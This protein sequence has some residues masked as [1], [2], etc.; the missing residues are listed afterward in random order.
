MSTCNKGANGMRTNRT[1]AARQK[2]L[3]FAALKR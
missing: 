1:C 2:H 3:Q